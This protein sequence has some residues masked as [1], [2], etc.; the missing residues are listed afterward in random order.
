MS[1]IEKVLS[2]IEVRLKKS[3][4]GPWEVQRFD[5]EGGYISYQV[6]AFQDY[7]EDSGPVARCSEITNLKYAKPNA[8][9]IAS[10][11]TDLARLVKALRLAVEALEWTRQIN[12]E[13]NERYTICAI[14]ADR[15]T[16]SLRAIEKELG[17]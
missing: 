4:P 1:E 11:P 16:E 14:V 15:A 9:L 13:M 8:Q 17:E 6:E 10:A 12:Q 2:E 5:N 7:D 3:T